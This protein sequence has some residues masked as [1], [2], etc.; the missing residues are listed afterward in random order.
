MP[1]KRKSTTKKRIAKKPIVTGWRKFR[2]QI[3]M[4]I[5]VL[6]V[7]VVSLGSVGTEVWAWH[8]TQIPQIARDAVIAVVAHQKAGEPVPVVADYNRSQFYDQEETWGIYTNSK[9]LADYATRII[10]YYLRERV[11]EG[12]YPDY[13][14]VRPWDG[15]TSFQ[16]GGRANCEYDPSVGRNMCVVWINARYFDDPAWQ[17]SRDI[18]EVFVHEM[19]HIQGGNFLNPQDGETWREKSAILESNT[20]AATLEV[21]AAMCNYGDE[22]A[23]KTFWY[24]LENLSRLSLRSRLREDVWAY[25]LFANLFLRSESDERASRKSDRFW[26][27][28]EYERNEIIEKYGANPWEYHVLL[29]LK[30]GTRLESGTR[31]QYDNPGTFVMLTLPFDDTTDLLGIWSVWLRLLTH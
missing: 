25:D 23:C 1:A 7:T 4:G 15:D 2:P 9:W 6:V 5:L 13:I 26:A 27:G 3:K 29:Y 18:L 24:E 30:Y 21:L 20:S 11:G 10:P 16:V 12:I 22:L 14:V 28:H 31:A 19:V 8:N 17:D